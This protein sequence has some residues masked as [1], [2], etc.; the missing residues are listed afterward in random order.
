M[1]YKKKY[2]KYKQKYLNLVNL[3]PTVPSVSPDPSLPKSEFINTDRHKLE[4]IDRN[5]VNLIPEEYRYIEGR[6]RMARI[7]DIYK[8]FHAFYDRPENSQILTDLILNFKFP[9]IIFDDE[10]P[11]RSKQQEEDLDK[12]PPI[13]SKLKN[14]KAIPNIIYKGV[15]RL[16]SNSSVYFPF[17]SKNIRINF[18]GLHSVYYS[19]KDILRKL[20]N[21]EELEYDSHYNADD[22]NDAMKED[23]KKLQSLHVR[24][25]KSLQ[26]DITLG[27]GKFDNLEILV[28]DV[29][30]LYPELIRKF[31]TKSTFPKLKKLTLKL[32]ND[33]NL[34]T[35]LDNLTNL[36]ELTLYSPSVDYLNNLLKKLPK[37][38]KLSLSSTFRH[39]D[40]LISPKEDLVI[41]YIPLDISRYI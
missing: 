6:I 2:F 22:L 5:Q 35:E 16:Y 26:K 8:S 29:I 11:D 3:L 7:L 38:K 27:S 1:D 25:E 17:P 9:N 13:D 23:F 32:A 36:E 15:K 33:S 21:L 19:L 34:T 4:L 31:F 24:F 14:S 12:L 30:I 10:F 39:K 28:L 41:E 40:L 18:L 20:P 37:L